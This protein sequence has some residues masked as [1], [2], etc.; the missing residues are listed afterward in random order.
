MSK[1][2]L[3][4]IGSASRNSFSHAT[5][6]H[7]QR[8][9]PASLALNVSDISA[10]P[11]YDRDYDADSPAAYARLRQAVAA[12]DGVLW[13][14]PEHNG[15]PSAMLKNAI[16]IASR[17]VGQSQWTGKPLGIVAVGAGM[18]GGIRAADQLRLIAASKF[19]NMP[20]FSQ[21][22]CVAGVL[23]GVF[24]EQGELVQESVRQMLQDFING[25]ADFV[26]RY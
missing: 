16:D 22:A 14:S 18:A 11:L 26:A 15:A 4:L 23:S 19:V 24:H 13:V 1:N 25:F 9:A 5:V 3:V 12:A 17:P 2:I 21:N 20:A 7:L 10:L 6:R 8:I